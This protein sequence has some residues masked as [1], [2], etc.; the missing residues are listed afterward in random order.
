[1]T[2]PN[3]LIRGGAGASY[4]VVYRYA[5]GE[6]EVYE[7]KNGYGRIGAGRW[8]ALD[9]TQKLGTATEPSDAEKLAILWAEYKENHG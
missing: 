4:P 8:I 6:Y 1:M 7:E 2:I 3:L 9:Y 5:T